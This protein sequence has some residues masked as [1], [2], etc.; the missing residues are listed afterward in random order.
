MF[1][2]GQDGGRDENMRV[3]SRHDLIRARHFE[4]PDAHE[5]RAERVVG[6]A[7]RGAH[8]DCGSSL[9]RADDREQPAEE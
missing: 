8:G 4:R 3:K 9:A 6:V 5:S 7:G 1:I 2:L